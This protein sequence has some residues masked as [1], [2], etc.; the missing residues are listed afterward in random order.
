[1]PSPTYTT[2]KPQRDQM[3]F[4]NYLLVIKS[5]G[6]MAVY[7]PIAEKFEKAA[8]PFNISTDRARRIIGSMLKS[9]GYKNNLTEAECDELLSTLI[10]LS[11]PADESLEKL[12]AILES[13][14]KVHDGL[15]N[16]IESMKK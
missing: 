10:V 13:A 11:A 8:A 9:K 1:M 14:W 7:I 5:Y 2:Q 6:D 3:L 12:N 16:L 15:K 4:K